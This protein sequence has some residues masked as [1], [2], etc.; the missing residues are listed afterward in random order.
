MVLRE[1]MVGAQLVAI[2]FALLVFIVNAALAMLLARF[3]IKGKSMSSLIWSSGMRMFAI[4]VLV[5]L[6]FAFGVYSEFLAKVY[7]LAIAMPLLAFSIGHMQ[8]VRSRK[9]KRAYYYYCIALVS[10]LLYVLYTANIWGI[11]NGYEIYGALP[12][13]VMAVSLFIAVSSLA[14]ISF[15]SVRNYVARRRAKVLAI[16]P[17]AILFL[18]V[19]ILHFAA[20]PPLFLYYCQ[21]LGIALVW[22][23]FV[24]FA[25][26]KE[27]KL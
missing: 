12:L 1:M 11:F 22:V 10:I 21:L 9:A 18:A 25:G 26:V 24:G 20:L 19:D 5:E 3:Y 4:A 15:V 14:V 27:Y 17:G 8:F 16:I 6:L 7:L 23:G 13:P 2:L